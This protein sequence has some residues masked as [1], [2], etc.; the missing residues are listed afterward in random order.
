MICDLCG[1]A[2]ERIVGKISFC[3]TIRGVVNLNWNNYTHTADVGEC[4]KDKLFADVNFRKRMTQKEY[5]ASRRTKAN[6]TT[7]RTRRKEAEATDAGT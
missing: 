2:T 1:Q 5:Q 4:C 6:S 3:P 7:V